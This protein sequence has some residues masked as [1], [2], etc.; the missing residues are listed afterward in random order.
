M[1]N[2]FISKSRKINL[3]LIVSAFMGVAISYSDFYLF[4]FMLLIFLVVSIYQIK[5]NEFLLDISILKKN[6]VP[7]L[8]IFLLWYT[9][10][11]FWAPS[12]E[13][14]LKYIFYITCGLTITLSFISF[15]ITIKNLNKIFNILS[16]FVL[17]EISIGL[18]ESFTSLRMPISSYS[19]IAVSFG[20][21]PINFSELDNIFL[22]SNVR[23]PTGFRWNTNDL[24]ICM[25][26]SLPFFLCSKKTVV[27]LLG[28]LSITTIIVMTASRAVFLAMLLVYFLYLFLIKKRIGTLALIT[29]ISSIILWSMFQLVE[30]EN[31]R[32]NELANSLEALLLFLSGELDIGGSIEWRRELVDN[33]LNAFYDSYGLGLGAGG[34]VANQEIM[35]PVAGRFTSMHNFWVELLVE[36]GIFIAT[37]ISFWIVSIILR[38]FAISRSSVNKMLKYYSQSLFLSLIAFIPAAI[39]GS[40][41]IY[42]FP[43]WIMF[44]FAISVILLSK[45]DY[46]APKSERIV[47]I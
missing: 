24:A 20:K 29:S 10:S 17:I 37:I 16:V 1:A 13:L 25:I 7:T 6:Y 33:G 34:S 46:R 23:P 3:G 11:L 2:S 22:Y 12:I 39:A 42:F 41:T 38:L 43:M 9:L 19:S 47:N 36:G 4:H 28:I 45:N 5:N 40:S 21:E 18:I 31:P 32:I 8:I 26:I 30:S 35:G 27:K 44:G 14:G 15:S